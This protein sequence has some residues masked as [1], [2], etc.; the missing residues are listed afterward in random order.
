MADSLPIACSLDAG[1]LARRQV[2]LRAGVLRDAHAVEPLAGGYR[3]FFRD[4]PDLVARL[5]AVID[6]ERRCCRFL[7]FTLAAEPDL[8]SVILDVTGP[9]GAREFLESWIA[10]SS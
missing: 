3:W 6:A 1:G 8:G 5:G 7:Q 2:E 9:A 10:P 4:G